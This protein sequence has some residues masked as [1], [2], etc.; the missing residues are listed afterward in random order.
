VCCVECVGQLRADREGT[1]RLERALLPEECLQVA[2]LDVSHHEVE[3][4]V[5]FACVVDRHDV[6]M[7]QRS[8]E[9]GLGQEPLP[10]AIVCR[11]LGRDQL[12]GDGP[13]QAAVVSAV[14][15]SHSASAD[16]FV[17]PV[18]EDLGAD[19]LPGRR[20]PATIWRLRCRCIDVS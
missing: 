3:P 15:D 10:E 7:L 19:P 11:S 12:H 2:A 6:R 5:E 13:F 9:L 17:D 20:H 14:D 8:G 16:Q 1:R 4:A 18:A